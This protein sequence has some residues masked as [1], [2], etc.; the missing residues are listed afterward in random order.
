MPRFVRQGAVAALFLLRGLLS[1]IYPPRRQSERTLLRLKAGIPEDGGVTQ[2][3]NSQES[4]VLYAWYKHRWATGQKHEA[5]V[6]VQHLEES[7]LHLSGL[8]PEEEQERLLLASKVNLKLALWR[9]A[10]TEELDEATIEA[11]MNN[12]RAATEAAPECSKAW[13]HWALFNVEVRARTRVAQPACFCVPPWRSS[14]PLCLLSPFFCCCC[15]FPPHLR[16]P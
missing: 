6:G 16:R 10:L 5:F 11:V 2:P 7:L 9:R 12:L 15:S 4:L 13:H 1:F 8:Q 3:R 14:I